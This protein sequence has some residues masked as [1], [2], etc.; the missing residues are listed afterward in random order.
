VIRFAELFE[1]G[2]IE[3]TFHSKKF[4]LPCAACAL[5]GVLVFGSMSQHECAPQAGETVF[6][7]RPVQHHQDASTRARAAR[8]RRT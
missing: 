8:N 7:G 5:C 4:V 1:K 6:C 2:K 3:M